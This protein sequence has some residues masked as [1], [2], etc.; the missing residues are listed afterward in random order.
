MC[1]ARRLR[2][3]GAPPR[4]PEGINASARPTPSGILLCLSRRPH[5]PTQAPDEARVSTKTNTA[6]TQPRTQQKTHPQAQHPDAGRKKAP[7]RKRCGAWNVVALALCG[8]GSSSGGA[9]SGARGARRQVLQR[10]VFLF[11]RCGGPHAQARRPLTFGRCG[12]SPPFLALGFGRVMER[13]SRT[14]WASSRLMWPCSTTKSI[15]GR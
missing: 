8:K 4:A 12:Y 6:Q 14:C 1:G 9:F 7:H 2:P 5:S 11:R 3:C 13:G 10:R 15:S